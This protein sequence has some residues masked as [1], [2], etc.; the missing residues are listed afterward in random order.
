MRP[1]PTPRMCTNANSQTAR[2]ATIV[3]RENDSGT[4]GIGMVKNG[5]VFATPGTNR[6][7]YSTKTTAL[8]AIAPANPATNDVHP[9]RNAISRPYAA[10]R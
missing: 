6:S 2:M 7:R 10:R 1:G 5:V 9:V 4:N 3:C 8:A